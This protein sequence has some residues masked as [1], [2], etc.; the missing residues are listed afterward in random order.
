MVITARRLHLQ[1]YSVLRTEDISKDTVGLLLVTVDG[2]GLQVCDTTILS[3][4]IA[5]LSPLG[6]HV[7]LSS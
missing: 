5:P 4:E 3:T 7:C 2:R 6:P 1:E